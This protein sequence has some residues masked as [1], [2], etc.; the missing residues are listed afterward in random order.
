[1]DQ[2]V[3]EGCVLKLS[4]RR[5]GNFITQ[6]TVISNGGIKVGENISNACESLTTEKRE[7]RYIKGKSE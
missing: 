6:F 3:F 4:Y 1:M 2:N 5:C 7:R